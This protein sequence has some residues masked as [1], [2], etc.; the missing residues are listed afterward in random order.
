MVALLCRQSKT[1]IDHISTSE[2]QCFR[3]YVTLG[4]HVVISFTRYVSRI[5]ALVRA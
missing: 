1:A 5:V 3:E 4:R 2:M